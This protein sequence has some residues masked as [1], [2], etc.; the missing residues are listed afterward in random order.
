MDQTINTHISAVQEGIKLVGVGKRGS[1]ELPQHLIDRIHQEI[2]EQPTWDGP[3]GAFYAGL[4]MK[5][6]TEAESKLMDVFGEARSELPQHMVE[7]ICGNTPENIQQL[8]LLLIQRK[9]LNVDQAFEIGEFL[10]SD[11]PGD[12]ARGLIAS[13]LRVRYETA[14]E[15]EGL[16]KSMES[17]FKVEFQRTP[18]QGQP[19]V[20]LAEPFD[21]VDHSYLV[22]PLVAQHIQ[23]LNYRV[24]SLVGRNSGPKFGNNLLDL[25]KVLNS[26]FVTTPADLLDQHQLYGYCLDQATLSPALDKWVDFRRDIIKRPFLATLERFVNPFD[27]QLL[28]ASAFHPPYGDKML[29][30]CERAGFP[31][32]VIVRNGME[33]TM[34]FPLIRNAKILCTVRSSNGLYKRHEFEFNASEYLGKNFAVEER[35][36]QPSLDRNIELIR[37]YKKSQ[38]TGYEL[39]DARVKVTCEGIQKA[40]EWVQNNANQG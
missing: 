17:T 22:T 8:C 13:L 15:Y 39:F 36:D 29:T 30:I 32:A 27:S 7:H 25:H 19:I 10:F 16:L 20:T 11:L 28:V 21:G 33:G 3:Q 5:G 18:P 35:L 37:T 38:Q 31:G 2:G 4:L 9:E 24:V 1:R 23:Q 14:A 12:G 34:N 26:K 6:V 40:I